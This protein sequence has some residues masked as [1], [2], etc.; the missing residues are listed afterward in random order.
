MA[1]ARHTRTDTVLADKPMPPS[2]PVY[3]PYIPG[4]TA[5]DLARCRL[6]LNQHYLTDYFS[7]GRDQDFPAT[8]PALPPVANPR[9]AVTLRRVRSLVPPYW[10]LTP[11]GR[12]MVEHPAEVTR[13]YGEGPNPRPWLP[14][15]EKSNPAEML[16]SRTVNTGSHPDLCPLRLVD[17]QRRPGWNPD[18]EILANNKCETSCWS[19]RLMHMKD[20]ND[21]PWRKT[22]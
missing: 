12:A 2:K 6:L 22:A 16:P 15:H 3:L 20:V 8:P 7:P 5:E 13:R 14:I 9:H 21:C 1:H 18:P 17:N 11:A 10:T 4:R 19:C